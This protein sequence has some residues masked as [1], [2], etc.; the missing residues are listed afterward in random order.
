MATSVS[1]A[2]RKMKFSAVFPNNLDLFYSKLSYMTELKALVPKSTD[3][4]TK[5]KQMSKLLICESASIRPNT[6]HFVVIKH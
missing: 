4:E 3:S 6:I 2:L 1:N 5:I